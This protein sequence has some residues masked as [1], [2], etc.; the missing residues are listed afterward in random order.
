MPYSF[1]SVGN[2]RCRIKSWTA[3]LWEVPGDNRI[4]GAEMWQGKDT[5]EFIEKYRFGDKL[6][7]M[8]RNEAND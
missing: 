1:S 4:Y 6:Y 8:S 3:I 2:M 5:M 7:E